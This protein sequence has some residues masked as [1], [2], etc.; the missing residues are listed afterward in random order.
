MLLLVDVVVQE[1]DD[2]V[3][4][5]QHHASAAVALAANLVKGLADFDKHNMVRAL[6]I[7]CWKKVVE[8]GHNIPIV[9]K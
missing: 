8:S 3:D 7:N 1:L 5:S 6:G 4:V 2:E 9:T